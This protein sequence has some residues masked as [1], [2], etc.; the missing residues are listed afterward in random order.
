M[1][2]FRAPRES[3]GVLDAETTA[4]L[5]EG[6]ADVAVVLDAQGVVSDI[7][8]GSDD[9]AAELSPDWI[10]QPWLETVS[11]E[12]RANLEDLLNEAAEHSVTR[13]RQVTHPS[14]RGADI[15][16]QYRAL[17]ADQSGRI[18]AVGRNLQGMAALQQQLVDAQQALERDYWRFRQVETRY[19]LLFR[20]VSEAILI[21]DAPTQR[22]VEANPAAG[23]M[24]GETPTRIIGR[25]FPEGF[26]NDSTQSI[27]GLLAGVRAAGRADDVRAILLDS[28][29][30]FLVSASL[31]RQENASFLLVRLSPVIPDASKTASMPDIKAR[32]LRV[33]ESA[34][35]CV[36]ITDTN[37][38]ILTANS[39]FLSLTEIAAEQQAR[40]ESLDRWLG[41]PGVD[42]NVLMANLRQHTTVRLFATTL[43]GEY[44]STTE[45]EISAAAVRNGERPYFGFFIRDVGRRLSAE[46]P[47]SPEQTRWLDQ[48]TERVGRVPLKELVRESTDTI[49]RLCIE[50]ALKLT[51]D[52]RASAAELLG[53]S[54]QSLYVKIDRYGI[55]A[56]HASESSGSGKK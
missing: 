6:M 17:R 44:G 28:T 9:L 40:G 10:G 20:M 7:A 27:N 53:L 45:V 32:Y 2:S 33:L 42:L 21:I 16:M 11:P 30:E 38:T 47:T 24:L 37:G 55:V 31:L 41:R 23:Q 1:S 54:R 51:G 56:D 35:D 5:V 19:R 39:T 48:L 25:P 18:I 4:A 22:V 43:R 26:D 8:Y 29:Q 49:E 12:T 14:R 15:P 13:W 50:A 52:N 46:Q 34:P 3:L 36:V